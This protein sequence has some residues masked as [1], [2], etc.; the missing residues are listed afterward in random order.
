MKQKYL[1]T[2]LALFIGM[3]IS[4]K[5]EKRP[6]GLPELYPFKVKILSE[7]KPLEGAGVALKSDDKSLQRWPCGAKTN[8]EGIANCFTYG[9]EGAPA[10]SF[11]VVVNKSAHEGSAQA[12]GPVDLSASSEGK[13]AFHTID[14][15]YRDAASTPFTVEVVAGKNETIPEFD[16]GSEIHEEVKPMGN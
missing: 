6:E 15:K 14:P 1:L 12:Q 4:C 16:V 2:L 3:M 8:A 10:G 11:K 13:K 9:F 5:G 7:G